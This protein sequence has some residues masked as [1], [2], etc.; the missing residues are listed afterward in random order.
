VWIASVGIADVDVFTR[1]AIGDSVSIYILGEV[2]NFIVDGKNQARSGDTNYSID[3]SL[4]LISPVALLGSPYSAN[5]SVHSATS[6]MAS[7]AVTS[8][9][10]PVDWQM[11]DWLI[12]AGQF[13]VPSSTPLE[14]ARRVVAVIGGTLYSNPDGTVVCAMIDKV[15]PDQYQVTPTGLD[16]FDSDV[17]KS[18]SKLAP[19]NGFDRVQV[20][21]DTDGSSSSTDDTS[22]SVEYEEYND[23][24]G[25]VR[26][27]PSPWRSV[28]LFHSGIDTTEI[29]PLDIVSRVETETVEFVGGDASVKYPVKSIV[30]MT[31]HTTD[32]GSVT[33]DG[34]NLTS[35][36][37]GFSLLEVSYVTESYEWFVS[38]E[39]G[40]KI[41]FV[42]GEIGQ[43]AFA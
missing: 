22:D 21:N 35:S 25:T 8:V 7:V 14:I 6:I 42:L 36:N 31:W 24:S 32:L 41:Q 43:V 2:Y 29:V 17:F 18:S 37:A 13:A 34:R 27:Y 11:P 33:F 38:G 26:G 16:L 15:S 5:V 3:C 4:S 12:P 9:L 28:A 39:D 1:I 20:D 23:L 30:A 10:G 40:T 19:F